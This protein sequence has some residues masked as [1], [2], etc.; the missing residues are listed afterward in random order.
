M[1]AYSAILVMHLANALGKHFISSGSIAWG[2][3]AAKLFRAPFPRGG[4]ASGIAPF[5]LG[6]IGAVLTLTVRAYRGN[7]PEL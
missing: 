4:D 2:L 7:T 1:K 3:Y 6:K 5:R